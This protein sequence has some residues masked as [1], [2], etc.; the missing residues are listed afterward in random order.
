MN[1]LE[2][3]FGENTTG[4]EFPP[5]REYYEYEVELAHAEAELADD[6]SLIMNGS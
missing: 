1:A 4:I 6:L 3:A 5:E 2:S